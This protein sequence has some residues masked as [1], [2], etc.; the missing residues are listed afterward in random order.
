MDGHIREQY[1]SKL[2]HG[3][4]DTRGT[5]PRLPAVWTDTRILRPYHSH[6]V[7]TG[8]VAPG[9]FLG[10]AGLVTFSSDGVLNVITKRNVM[11]P[12]VCSYPN[13]A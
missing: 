12:R 8:V 6:T 9:A 7:T 10:H 11:V 2:P 3:W 5:C 1:L 4:T 13:D